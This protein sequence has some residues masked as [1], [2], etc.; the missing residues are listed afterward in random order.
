M[1]TPHRLI[2]I[3]LPAALIVVGS[4]AIVCWVVGYMRT[5]LL[6]ARNYDLEPPPQA[7]SA[8]ATAQPEATSFFNT[9]IVVPPL[10]GAWPCF[11]GANH[12]GYSTDT[13]ALA[14]TWPTAG[15]KQLWSINVGEGYAGPAVLNGRVYVID[16]DQVGQADAL[17]CFSLAD[18]SEV[19][20]RSYHEIVK[21]NHGMSRTVPAVNDQYVVSLGPKC[22]VLCADAKT[23]AQKWLL[24]LVAEYGTSVPEWYAGQCPLIDNG[25]AIIAP[26]GSALM[27]AVDLATGKVLWKTPNPAGCLTRLSFR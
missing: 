14:N 10:P 25:H 3:D 27:I 5:P 6:P 22:H 17:R 7:S 24:D 2:D 15:P 9:S 26:G 20:R 11:R 8:Q 19:W 21:R 18:G 4:I 16:Y 12:S 13:L 1:K 23:G